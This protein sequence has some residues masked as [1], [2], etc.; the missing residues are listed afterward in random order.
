MKDY[1]LLTRDMHN[2]A[3]YPVDIQL[4]IGLDIYQC[5]KLPFNFY[6]LTLSNIL[7]YASLH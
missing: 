2:G 5:P 4:E 3:G 6:V 1:L 7:W